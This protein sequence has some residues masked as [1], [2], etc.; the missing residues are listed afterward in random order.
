MA[1]NLELDLN[2][3]PVKSPIQI[4]TSSD[5]YLIG[6]SNLLRSIYNGGGTDGKLSL[7]NFENKQSPFLPITP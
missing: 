6:V 7:S 1:S 3:I 5:N 4:L 2:S